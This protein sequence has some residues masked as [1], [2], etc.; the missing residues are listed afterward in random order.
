[1]AQGCLD[2]PISGAALSILTARHN[3]S[4][5]APPTAADLM[6]KR[7]VLA[8][9]AKYGG[10]AASILTGLMGVKF[11]QANQAWIEGATGLSTVLG[12]AVP[13]ANK[14]APVSQS[15]AGGDLT[16]GTNGCGAAWFY[17][18]ELKGQGPFVE[19]IP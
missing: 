15:N 11:I 16:L 6:S 18:A 8:N 12:I 19:A 1:M 10:I 3:L 9:V 2:K 5:L 13:L 14:N 4:Y 17:A 7:S